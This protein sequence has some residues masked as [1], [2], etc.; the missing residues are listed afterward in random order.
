MNH[1]R[2]QEHKHRPGRRL[3]A[4]AV[5]A[6]LAATGGTLAAVPATAATSGSNGTGTTA[7]VPANAAD[8]APQEA[9]VRFPLSAEIVSAG[10][11]GFLS[12]SN[13]TTPEYRWTRYTDGTSTVLPAAASVTGG[14]SDIVVTGD[15]AE[16]DDSRFLKVHDMATPSAAPVEVDLAGLGADYWF[17]GAIG[18]TLIV[19]VDTEEGGWLPHL[20][21]VEGGSLTDRVVS[22]MPSG[23]CDLNATAHTAHTVLFD[24]G[25][26]YN[27]VR[28]KAVVDLAAATVVSQHVQAGEP[29]R[30]L[31]AAVSDTHTAWHEANDADRIIQ[32]ARR[33]TA[34]RKQIK[35][36]GYFGD[37]FRLLG[38]WVTLGEPR[39]TEY[40]NG[41]YA[42]VAPT[43]P[44]PFVAE[45][46]ETG[47]T[48]QLLT[49]ASS[50][51]PAPDGSLMVRGGTTAMGEG[52]YRVALGANGKPAATMV[53]PTGQATAVT[54]LG[55]NV[56]AVITGEQLTKG[57]D[58]SWD[59]SRGDAYVWATL[60]HVRTGQ[61][62][63]W[64]LVREG[65][66][67]ARRTVGMHWNGKELTS[68]DST[69]PALNGEYTWEINALPDDGIGPELRAT[70]RFTVTRPVAPH[71]YNENGTPDVL[72]RDAGGRLVRVGMQPSA[73]GD[74]LIRSGVSNVGPGWQVY[75][76]M[77]SVGNVAGTSVSDAIARDRSGVLWLYSGTGNANAPFSARKRIGGGWG[78][79]DRL[80]G[81]SDLTNDGRAD[82]VATDRT[83]VLW[84]YSG[85]G[86]ANAPFSARKRIGGGWGVYN[87]ITAVGNLAGAAAGDLAAR[88]K[89]GVLW[90][91]LG[92]G[93]GTF[94]SRTK[95]G[96]GWSTYTDIIG[97]GD[98]NG[99]GRSDL[100]ALKR[101]ASPKPG[102]YFYAGT[103]DWRAPFKGAKGNDVLPADLS[104][105]TG[106]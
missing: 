55:S 21:T 95:I 43:P 65:G 1:T 13:A 67:P 106:F 59:L 31:E 2:A 30:M 63:Q 12:R 49:H 103:G 56:P 54:L 98:G 22:G 41:V 61:K 68:L 88:D 74:S 84:L 25:L 3:T 66:T 14:V 58:M 73:A 53:A 82:M 20:V 11:T 90:L 15:A 6:V 19:M 94:A 105:E 86:N 101:G 35:A 23:V 39:S 42:G 32:V 50:S 4:L 100:L 36:P 79:Y 16:I 93:D 44:R 51:A 102:S 40:G 28:G 5:T 78:I 45:S 27:E 89:D 29:W 91:Y 104:Y 69:G 10:I 57:V 8:A 46:A 76:R 85:T 62:L 70:G 17:R 96:A 37:D 38:D 18:S 47:E 80:A 71:D 75:D 60:V 81:G 52:L 97:I 9:T 64:P 34:E 33:G 72:V 48:V 77:E 92:K 7:T 99:D 87:E 24:C 26:G 83:G